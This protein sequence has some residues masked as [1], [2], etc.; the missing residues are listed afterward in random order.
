MAQFKNYIVIGASKGLGAALVEELLENE[1]FFVFAVSRTSAE[2]IPDYE[3][4]QKS[5]RFRYFQADISDKEEVSK[6]TDINNFI[7][8]EQ[9]C[10]IFNAACL[11]TDVDHNNFID[12]QTLREVKNTG[13]DGLINILEV[14]QSNLLTYGGVFV[15]ISSFSTI[16]PAICPGMIAYRAAKTF[17][18]TL[19]DDLRFTWRNNKNIKIMTV[20]LG[21]MRKNKANP[22]L[23]LLFPSYTRVAKKIIKTV[24]SNNI[25]KE[26]NYTFL[27]NIVYRFFA[28]MP[29]IIYYFTFHIVLRKTIAFIKNIKD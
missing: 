22:F 20:N 29:S 9:A 10:I 25:P 5:G 2:E 12:F 24:H 16:S 17:L 18:N 23:E 19:I 15:G 26:L 6:L 7:K 3:Q 14:F 1:Q 11:K 13:I 8:D 28:L 4:W 27:Y 21:Y